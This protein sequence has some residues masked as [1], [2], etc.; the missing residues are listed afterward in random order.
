M[1]DPQLQLPV[2]QTAV[3]DKPPPSLCSH[4]KAAP[5]FWH[6]MGDAAGQWQECQPSAHPMALAP[7]PPG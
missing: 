6:E 5:A 2:I 3:T 4:L 7:V 1:K